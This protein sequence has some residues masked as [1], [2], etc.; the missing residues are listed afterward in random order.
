MEL[1]VV[2][3]AVRTLEAQG[4]PLETITGPQVRELIGFGSYTSIIEHLRTIRGESEEHPLAGDLLTLAKAFRPD[5]PTGE[6]MVMV[7]QALGILKET[8]ERRKRS[9]A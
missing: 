9:A 3:D 1:E 7:R 8:I 5:D 4:V 6:G 2:K